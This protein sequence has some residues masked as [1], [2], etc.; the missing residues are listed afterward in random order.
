MT[1][2]S[3]GYP[4]SASK[5]NRL[6]AKVKQH[7]RTLRQRQS[8]KVRLRNGKGKYNNNNFNIS[9][10]KE[11]ERTMRKSIEKGAIELCLHK[12]DSFNLLI[13]LKNNKVHEAMNG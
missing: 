2:I 5:S 1:H 4:H 3:L 10:E 12:H 13:V 11:V 9:M 8:S 7:S 6:P